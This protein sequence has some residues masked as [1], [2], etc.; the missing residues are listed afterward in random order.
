M[1]F[2]AQCREAESLAKKLPPSPLA[3][4]DHLTYKDVSIPP[5]PHQTLF[6]NAFA[7]ATASLLLTPARAS[8]LCPSPTGLPLIFS[9][10]DAVYEPSDDTFLLIDAIYHD[11]PKS[12]SQRDF[13]SDSRSSPV[14]SVELG[15]GSGVNVVAMANAIAR[16]QGASEGGTVNAHVY[17][18]D[19]NL[20]AVQMTRS[21]VERNGS[22]SEGVKFEAVQEDLL[23]E[24][25]CHP[26]WDGDGVDFVVFNPPYVP[27]PEEEVGG[28]GIEASWAGGLDGRVVIDRALGQISRVLRPGGV[29]YMVTVDDNKPE[30]LIE[31]MKAEYGVCGGVVL[32]KKARNEMLSILKFCK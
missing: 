22:H 30:E 26:W 21:T 20:K 25:S 6:G 19:I 13:Q 2:A 15:S 24:G 9:Q 11:V 8:L 12:L 1:S 10:Y 16:Y 28:S 27:T 18:T 14:R 3:S 23:G 32:R 5:R 31:T 17:A 4:L 29:C 7:H